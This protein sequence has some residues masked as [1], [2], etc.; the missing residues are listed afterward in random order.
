[1]RTSRRE[2]YFPIEWG[3]R[4]EKIMPNDAIEYGSPNSV[5]ESAQLV[6]VFDPRMCDQ[7]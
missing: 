3:W 7:G 5:V 1:M 6:V 2:H 4:N